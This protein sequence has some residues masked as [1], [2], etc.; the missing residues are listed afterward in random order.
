[1]NNRPHRRQF[2]R[3]SALTTGALAALPGASSLVA[4]AA[5]ADDKLPVAVVTTA[6]YPVSHADVIA[7]KILRGYQ[8][9]GGA[10]PRLRIASLY[11]DQFPDSDISRDLSREFG[12]PIMPSI[13]AAVTLDSDEVRVAGVLLIG[14]HGQYPVVPKTGQKMYPRKRFFDETAAAFRRCGK[15]VPVFMDKHFSYAWAEARAMFDAARE[16]NIPLLAGSSLPV[17]WRMPAVELPRDCELEAAL[18]VGY[19]PL[20][21]Y[22]FHALETYQCMVERR[23]GGETGVAAV[24]AF[25]GDA[26][27]DADGAGRW[28]AE[29]LDAALAHMPGQTRGAA[30]VPREDSAVYRLEHRD[31][32][33]GDIVM[34][35]GLTGGFGFAA[36]IKGV[37]EPVATWFK[38]QDHGAFGHFAYQVDA[39]DATV[40]TGRPV[41]PAE[42]TLLTTGVLDRAMH[43]LAEGGPR[44]ETPELAVAYAAS[45]WGFANRADDRLKLP[46][47]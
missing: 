22:G 18:A 11:V 13:D 12:F 16:L 5:A 46:S 45:D 23:R 3:Q 27:R 30:W 26:V 41:Y 15:S 8:L 29:L 39:I 31:G 9:D 36:K 28:N 32:L 43:S 33:R 2:L 25:K 6:Y 21:D 38:L 19:G 4:R 37:A 47:D 44:Y 10:G 35:N 34:V 17:A 20:E 14:E 1:M 24:Q 40:A 42:R 7:T